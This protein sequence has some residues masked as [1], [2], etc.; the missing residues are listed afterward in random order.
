VQ[1]AV[2]KL[3][4]ADPENRTSLLAELIHAAGI[5]PEGAPDAAG[6]AWTQIFSYLFKKNVWFVTARKA[7]SLPKCL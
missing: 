1:C 7:Y 5:T 4:S 6:K 3:V 2:Q